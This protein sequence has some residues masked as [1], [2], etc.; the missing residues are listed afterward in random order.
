MI[1]KFVDCYIIDNS[2][3][4][5]ETQSISQEIHQKFI[6]TSEIQLQ[7]LTQLVCAIL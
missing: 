4:L 2:A 6:S 1:R 5:T 7:T 3:E